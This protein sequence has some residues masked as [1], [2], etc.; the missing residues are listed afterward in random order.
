MEKLRKYITSLTE[1]SEE[2][3]NILLPVLSRLEFRK[4]EYLLR[5]GEVCN[6][7]FFIENGCCRSYYEKDGV[8]KNTAF[9]FEND[10]AT[11]IRSFGSGEKSLYFIRAV[12][13][14]IIIAFDKKKLMEATKAAP[15]IE[16]LGRC[17]IRVFAAR[18][19]EFASLLNL[20]TAQER[21][22][23]LEKHYPAMLQRVSLT[24]LS[25]FLGVA[26]ETLSRIR[27]KRV[28]PSVL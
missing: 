9:Y 2:S 18:Q 12:E 26:R 27:R 10:I 28:H 14:L 1:F 13:P 5:A 6:A 8:E 21:Y 25:S 16:A 22:E 3:W 24:Q 7:L 23:Y 11:N 4:G 17:C 20:Y 19:D 15:Q